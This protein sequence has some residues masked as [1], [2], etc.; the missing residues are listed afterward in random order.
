MN[1][2]AKNTPNFG[3][4]KSHVEIFTNQ[5]CVLPLEHPT[6]IGVARVVDPKILQR[7]ESKIDSA[8]D[9]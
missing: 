8:V 4:P 5:K 7:D 2:F 6:T 1:I 3:T 9:D